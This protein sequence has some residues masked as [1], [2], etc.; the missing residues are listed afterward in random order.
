MRINNYSVKP[1][2]IF[3]GKGAWHIGLEL[4]V[5]PQTVQ[6]Q[7]DGLEI[8]QNPK[9]MYA[10][11]DGSLNDYGYELVTHPIPYERWLDKMPRK[12]SS[13]QQF[14]EVLNEL[15]QMDYQS[16]YSGNCGLHIHICRKALAI[17][18][19]SSN[20][21]GTPQ[22]QLFRK[23]INGPLFATLSQRQSGEINRWCRLR[24]TYWKGGEPIQNEERHEAVNITDNTIE[25]RLFRGNLKEVRVRKAI[26]A[27]ISAV[28]FAKEKTGE[29]VDTETSISN[30][31]DMYL[32]YVKKHKKTYFN[33]HEYMQIERVKKH[34][35]DIRERETEGN[36]E[37]L[38]R[39]NEVYRKKLF[40]ITE[41]INELHEKVRK[42]ANKEASDNTLEWRQ[43]QLKE[44]PNATENFNLYSE[45]VRDFY[46]DQEHLIR[47]KM[48]E[49]SNYQ[50]M[51]IKADKYRRK[52][53]DLSLKLS[54]EEYICA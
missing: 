45:R 16:H 15:T 3:L 20:S 40:A 54:N 23:L 31:E 50:S 24:R 4:E 30:L 22:F 2:P 51:S 34:F 42:Q 10:K 43:K 44:S 38:I 46:N 37:E 17:D 39:Q 47:Q 7:I 32:A 27:V 41:K 13:V 48:I 9:F 18:N 28:Q 49:N 33:L 11:H 36:K 52:I 25:I 5:E 29:G 8:K 19:H 1:K 53:H 26:E 12:N 6:A 14:T 21:P 35:S